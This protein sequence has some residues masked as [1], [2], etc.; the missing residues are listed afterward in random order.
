MHHAI[1]SASQPVTTNGIYDG[2]YDSAQY[3]I[4]QL[5]KRKVGLPFLALVVVVDSGFDCMTPEWWKTSAPHTEAASAEKF[6][7]CR[8]W[9]GTQDQRSGEIVIVGDAQLKRI[10]HTGLDL[11][12][13][14]EAIQALFE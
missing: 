12:Y 9:K 10:M 14:G 6:S 1:R 2:D 5:F 13:V 8:R 3:L 7:G 4:Q 11:P